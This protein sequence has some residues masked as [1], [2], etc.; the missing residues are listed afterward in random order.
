MVTI[1]DIATV[2][3]DIGNTPDST[4]VDFDSMAVFNCS[5]HGTSLSIEW[6]YNGMNYTYAANPC[7][8]DLDVCV[9]ELEEP[10][11]DYLQSRFK[12]VSASMNGTVRCF[13]RQSFD[14]TYNNSLPVDD[15]T[16]EATL[17]VAAKISPTTMATTMLTTT[18]STTTGKRI[19]NTESIPYC[20]I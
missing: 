6:E 12:I 17:T 1:Y 15:R 5:A 10:S 4:S 11:R 9:M 18:V 7:T 13:V 16:F 19:C 20:L 2:P 3:L 8:S 14:G